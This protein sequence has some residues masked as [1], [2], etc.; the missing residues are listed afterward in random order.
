MRGATY[1]GNSYYERGVRVIPRESGQT[2][3]GIVPPC[4]DTGIVTGDEP[5]TPIELAVI[6][7]VSPKIALLWRGRPDA[8]LVRE[9]VGRLPRELRLQPPT[10]DERDEPIHLAGPWYGIWGRGS[11]DDVDLTA[12]YRVKLFVEASSVARYERAFLVASVPADLERP[13]TRADIRWLWEGTIELTVTC[14]NGGY[15]A[16]SISAHA[17]S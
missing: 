14:R 1:L 5:E 16:E 7:G 6:E 17:P 10:C 4:N 3:T 8:V 13:L 2:V 12:P 9:G 15:V 11:P